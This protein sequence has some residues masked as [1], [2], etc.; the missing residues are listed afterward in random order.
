MYWNGY[1]KEGMTIFF[2]SVVTD[3]WS[4]CQSLLTDVTSFNLFMTV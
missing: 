3:Q 4:V 1:L 2:D